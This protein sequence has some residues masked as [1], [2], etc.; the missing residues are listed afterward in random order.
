MLNINSNGSDTY[1]RSS[2]QIMA[3]YLKPAGPILFVK[4]ARFDMLPIIPN[5]FVGCAATPEYRFFGTSF[6]NGFDIHNSSL[7]TCAPLTL[8]NVMKD[9]VKFL[10]WAK[11]NV[12]GAENNKAV[13]IRNS[14]QLIRS[15]VGQVRGGISQGLNGYVEVLGRR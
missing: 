9:G 5:V 2:Y 4:S 13:S 15:G 1:Y 7:E 12:L 8:D 10:N 3:D 11:K 14:S 6:P